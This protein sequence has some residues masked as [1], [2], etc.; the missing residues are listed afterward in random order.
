MVVRLSEFVL[1]NGGLYVLLLLLW[2]LLLHR[3]NEL[4]RIRLGVAAAAAAATCGDATI[5][6][7]RLTLFTVRFTFEPLQLLP[8]AA[9]AALNNG[10]RP[11]ML[12]CVEPSCAL[13]F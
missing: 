3:L 12:G 1:S 2:L 7:S 11:M 6:S 5:C 13:T 9:A 10:F 4:V 8:A